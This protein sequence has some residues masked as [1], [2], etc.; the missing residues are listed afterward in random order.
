[1]CKNNICLKSILLMNFASLLNERKIYYMYLN[2]SIMPV[3]CNCMICLYLCKKSQKNHSIHFWY[4]NNF[5]KIAFFVNWHLFFLTINWNIWCVCWT[6]EKYIT[7]IW[8]SRSCQLCKIVQS[9]HNSVKN[10]F[11]FIILFS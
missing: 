6:T 5:V 2:F 11:L 10:W 3:V 4:V 9:N 8:I 1:M 7:H